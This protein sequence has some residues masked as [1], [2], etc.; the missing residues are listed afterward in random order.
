MV[1]LGH[2]VQAIFTDAN[3]NTDEVFIKIKRFSVITD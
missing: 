2:S 1:F 3:R